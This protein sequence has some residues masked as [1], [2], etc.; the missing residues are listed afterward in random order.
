MK[1]TSLLSLAGAIALPGSASADAG[2]SKLPP[3]SSQK[4]LTFEKDIQPL[5]EASC[6]GCHGENKQ[7]GDL[8]LDSLAAVLK[9]GEDSKVVVPN[10]SKE[11]ALVVAISGLDEEKTMPPKRR[12]GRDRPQGG[13]GG[14]GGP[15]GSKRPK[16]LTR[17]RGRPGAR[18]DRSRRE[19]T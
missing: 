3:P 6:I 11:S 8:R 7:Q 5:F 9:G 12:P 13:P 4:G 16:A 19:V 18:L 1:Q 15:G 17:R 14:P 2:L 10:K